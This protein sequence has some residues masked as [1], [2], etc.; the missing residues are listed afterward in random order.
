MGGHIQLSSSSFLYFTE[1]CLQP[2]ALAHEDSVPKLLILESFT[3]QMSWDLF[4]PQRES[5]REGILFFPETP[6]II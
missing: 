6:E 2:E 1:E 4:L 3:A 5:Y